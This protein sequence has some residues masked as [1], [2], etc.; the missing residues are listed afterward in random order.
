LMNTTWMDIDFAN[1]TVEVSPKNDTAHTWEWHIKDT[2]RRT[3][4][5]TNAMVEMLA[6]HQASQPDGYPYV[7]LPAERYD[8]VQARRK[9][10]A[11]TL[12]D[13]RKPACNFHRTF[14]TILA[15]AGLKGHFHDLRRTCLSNWLAKGL[16]E[17]DVMNLAGHSSFQTTHTFY[18]AVRHDLLDRARAVLEQSE[19]ANLLRTCCA[20]ASLGT[21]EKSHQAQVLD[22][23]LLTNR[24]RQD[25]NL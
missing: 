15:R 6:T 14:R 21:I 11:W 3:L 9:E 1:K 2:H 5:L 10:G 23:S 12:E 8:H 13:G 22:G 19:E 16:G 25:S 4:P 7:F 18:L 17:F 24:A 20:P